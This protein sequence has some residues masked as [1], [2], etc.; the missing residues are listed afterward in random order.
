MPKLIV[1]VTKRPQD[2]WILSMSEPPSLQYFTQEQIDTIMLPYF[3]EI[4]AMT[5]LLD[6]VDSTEGDTKSVEY[7]FDTMENMSKSKAVMVDSDLAK[8][9]ADIIRN[10]MVNNGIDPYTL[11]TQIVN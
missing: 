5:G 7:I 1:K 8:A 9:R 10:A 3:V 2:P 4:R 6:I 11:E